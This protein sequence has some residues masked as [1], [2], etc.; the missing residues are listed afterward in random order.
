MNTTLLI[1]GA[2]IF[3]GVLL[4]AWLVYRQ[5]RRNKQS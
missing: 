1:T 4:L 5:E 3:A 2:I